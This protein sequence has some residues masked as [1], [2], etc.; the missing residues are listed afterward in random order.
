M[1]VCDLSEGMIAAGRQRYSQLPI[2]WRLLPSDWKRLPFADASYDA[3]IA[4]SVFEYLD[5]V[6]GVLAE[7]RRVLRPGGKLYF[8]VP[9]PA[10]WSRKVEAALRPLAVLAL[11]FPWIAALPKIGEY[12]KYLK[13]SR[14]RFSRM[15]WREKGLR[16]GL[17]PA[18]VRLDQSHLA[19]NQA[20]MYLAFDRPL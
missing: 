3:I 16:A 5:T 13:V 7:C 8:S 6:E 12:L 11:R 9:N 18:E 19:A 20:L 10:H 2:D 4:S 1:T 14:A 15:E 17:R